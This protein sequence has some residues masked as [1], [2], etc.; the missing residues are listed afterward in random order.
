MD[1][2]LNKQQ[3]DLTFQMKLLLHKNKDFLKHN[4][5]VMSDRMRAMAEARTKKLLEVSAG[6][7]DADEPNEELEH[8]LST[9]NLEEEEEESTQS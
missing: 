6:L 5:G 4:A 2:K 8:L 1:G 7:R 9:V 3:N